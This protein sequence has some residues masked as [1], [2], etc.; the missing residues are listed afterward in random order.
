MESMTKILIVD[1]ERQ[2]SEHLRAVLEARL[3]QVTVA[4]S[5]TEAQQRVWAEKPD[6][7]LIGTIMPRGDAFLLHQWLR[8][9]PPFDN[10]PMIV[11]DA[12]E[13]DRLI[14]GWRKAEGL[15]LQA[16]EY[17]VKPL[18]PESMLPLFEKMVDK[19]TR[20]IRVLVA[21]DHAII[22]E[23]I[24]ALLGVQKDIQVVGEAV[25]GQDALEK[26][27]QL[28]PDI[29]LMDI[30]MP[31]MN[32]LEATRHIARDCEKTKVLMLSQYDDEENVLASTQV[33]AYGFI[34]KKSA[35]TQLLTAIRSL[36]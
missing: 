6:A 30:V 16:E 2:F 8:Q 15:Q 7:V 24:R 25:D 26:T 33:G 20:R 4:S 36:S 18:A 19:T 31:G 11:V 12:P 27:R 3:F 1:D 29:V 10:V 17:L 35:S 28:S 23:G 34:P 14:R 22:R 5:R 13:E 9:T 32:G 21:D